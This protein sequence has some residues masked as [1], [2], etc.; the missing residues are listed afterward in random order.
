[1]GRGDS[2][3]TKKVLQRRRQAKLQQRIVRRKEE[4]QEHKRVAVSKTAP[5]A[6]PAAESPVSAPK[7]RRKKATASAAE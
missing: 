2:R 1:M 6:K 7:T 3:R 5:A 4:A